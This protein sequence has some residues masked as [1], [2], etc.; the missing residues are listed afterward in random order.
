MLVASFVTNRS[1]MGNTR[2]YEDF[3][4]FMGERPHRLG[5]VSRLY[6]QLTATFLTE[7]LRNIYYGDNKKAGSF[8]SI[9]SNYFEWNIET[10]YIKRVP[11]AAV[12]VGTGV[13]GSEIEFVFGENYYQKEE[14]FKVENTGQQFFVVAPP[15]RRSDNTWSVMCRL[16]GDDY[17]SSIDPQDYNIGDLTK[18]IGNAKPELHD[19]GFVK[20]QSNVEK[21]RNYLTTIRVEDSYSAK[22]AAMEDTFIKIGQGK[23]QGCL[24]E[25]IYKLDPMKKNLVENFLYVR[26]NMMLLAKGTMGVDGKSTI[27]D[28][29]TGRPIQIGDGLI[30]QIER[31]ASKYAANKITI[32]TFHQVMQTM[33]EKADTPEGNHFVFLTNSLGWGIVQRVLG[34]YLANRKTD[35]A[36]LW[37]KSG[38]GKYVKVGNTFDSYEWGGNVISFKQDI[39]L[40]REYNKPYFLCI[41]LT[42]GKTSTTPPVMMFSLKGGDY[43]TYDMYG[44][45]LKDGLSS[46]VVSTA[47]AGGISGIW[48]YAGIG[49]MN[50]YKSFILTG[51]E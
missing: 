28:R 13:D 36:Y 20:Y 11:L 45:G 7:S 1:E 18:F 16:I 42:T 25:K 26:E 46:G 24:T 5:V 43:M 49:V 2:T 9:D 22:Y 51:K 33:V 32:N 3:S 15:V 14:I 6:P 40:T 41:D 44:P 37:S 19:I 17:S 35:G 12:P 34:S 4:K 21:M 30:P 23:D 27:S 48:G 38:E 10:N 29:N 8:Q 39:T 50:P 47:V 31:F